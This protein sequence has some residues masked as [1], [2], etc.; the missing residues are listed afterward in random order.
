MN[1]A[2]EDL[3]A[4]C[5]PL[6]VTAATAE[7]GGQSLGGSN[8]YGQKF[9][10][11]VLPLHKLEV[12]FFAILVAA[13]IDDDLIKRAK[14]NLA[15]IKSTSKQGRK[16]TDALRSLEAAI[17]GPAA[18]VF[19]D[20]DAPPA[21]LS[22]PVLPKAVVTPA[23]KNYLINIVIQAN[24]CYEARCH[25]ACAVL[26]RKFVEILIIELYESAG[27]EAEIKNGAG[28]YFMLSDMIDKL[29][30]A[31]HWHLGRE[32]KTT[33]PKLKTLG[34]RA[35]HNRRFV[36]TTGDINPVLPG[37]RALADDLLSLA[38]LK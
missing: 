36:A 30:A 18:T 5:R 20:Q 16:R 32:T 7:R 15:T 12:T 9:H 28:D 2:A 27:K 19:S 21:P 35:A 24:S 11:Q 26:I 37:L 13:S 17:H 38:G 23:K 25:D 4:A 31:P 22:E 8:R 29:K 10:D 1:K 34:D 6:L 3:L 14:S 33:L